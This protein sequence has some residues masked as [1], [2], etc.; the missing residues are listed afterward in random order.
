MQPKPNPKR[1]VADDDR[2]LELERPGKKS[3]QFPTNSVRPSPRSSAT[4]I[5]PP[6]VE[7][8]EKEELLKVVEQDEGAESL[9]EASL[10]RM[11]LNFEKRVLK[12]QELRIKFPDSPEKYDFYPRFA[13]SF[14]FIVLFYFII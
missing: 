12:N 2:E 8:S 7:T 5:A 14:F 9:D 13:S 11:I 1:E 4:Y 3:K 6:V 10:K